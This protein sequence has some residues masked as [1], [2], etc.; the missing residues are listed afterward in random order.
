MFNAGNNQIE[1][2]YTLSEF[3]KVL[4]GNFSAQQSEYNCRDL[5]QSSWLISHEISN[6]Q[7]EISVIQKPPRILGLL[8]LPVLGVTFKLISGETV[9]EQQFFEKFFRYFHKGGG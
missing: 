6:L 3:S 2:G 4:H 1:M 5:S 8:N 9:D 7:T